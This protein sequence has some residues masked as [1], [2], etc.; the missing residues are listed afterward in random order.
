MYEANQKD[1]DAN[2]VGLVVEE[3]WD[4]DEYDDEAEL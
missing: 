1:G 2:V 3:N 4:K